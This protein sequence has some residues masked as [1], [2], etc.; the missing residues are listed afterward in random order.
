MAHILRIDEMN[1]AGKIHHLLGNEQSL[2]ELASDLIRFVRWQMTHST[3]K[4]RLYDGKKYIYYYLWDFNEITG[5]FSEQ[6]I[7]FHYPLFL[8]ESGETVS[9]KLSVARMVKGRRKQHESVGLIKLFGNENAS[10]S[11]RKNADKINGHTIYVN[12]AVLSKKEGMDIHGYLKSDK[13]ADR[14]RGS[15]CHELMH[16]FDRIRMPKHTRSHI[17]AMKRAYK[18]YR[19]DFGI[20]KSI[21]TLKDFGVWKGKA[22]KTDSAFLSE[23]VNVR[24]FF[25]MLLYYVT[26]TEMNAYL[27]TFA[28]Q[29]LSLRTDDPYESDIYRRYHAIKEILET[30]F[31]GIA[32]RV[33]DER[34]VSDFTG[35]FPKLKGKDISTIYHK[36]SVMFLE[37]TEKYIHK[38]NTILY[39]IMELYEQ[40]K[41]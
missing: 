1:T 8:V 18:K 23:P 19:S 21:V 5:W 12:A 36:L 39:D 10:H 35:L 11:V 24:A 22:F 2:D 26:D 13:F 3:K 25:Y 28:N 34:T 31:S 41:F 20:G 14:F 38:M 7:D 37:K 17:D 9:V 15:V 32:D 4:R 30:D 16:A 29:M 40:H 6:G 27:Q 33:F